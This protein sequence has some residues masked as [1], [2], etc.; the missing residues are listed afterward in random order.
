VL[1][2]SV[3]DGGFADSLSRFRALCTQGKSSYSVVFSPMR[4]GFVARQLTAAIY[5]SRTSCETEL[6]SDL[7]VGSVHVAVLVAA[8]AARADRGRKTSATRADLTI[9]AALMLRKKDAMKTGRNRT[10]REKKKKRNNDCKNW[11]AEYRYNESKFQKRRESPSSQPFILLYR[12]T[13]LSLLCSTAPSIRTVT[14]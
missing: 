4:D 2:G 13:A 6:H 8:G 9:D 14:K 5:A 11:P 3:T 12:T 1:I 10:E 7:T